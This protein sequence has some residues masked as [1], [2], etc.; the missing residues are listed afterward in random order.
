MGNLVRKY[1]SASSFSELTGIKAEPNF[2]ESS[3]MLQ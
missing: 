1:F 3:E 2:S